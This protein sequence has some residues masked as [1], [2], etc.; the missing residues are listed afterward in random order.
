M[1]HYMQ[2]Q[3][4]ASQ[5][6]LAAQVMDRDE[7]STTSSSTEPLTSSSSITSPTNK[8]SNVN[9]TEKF[10]INA[11]D[12]VPIFLYVLSQTPSLKNTFFLRDILWNFCHPDL[13]QGEGGYILTV[14]ESALAYLLEDSVS[15]PE[16]SEP[17]HKK[18]N[19]KNKDKAGSH[20]DGVPKTAP[21]QAR[22][23]SIFNILQPNFNDDHDDT[24]LVRQSFT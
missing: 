11:D 24:A 5:E 18:K 2:Q 9:L 10:A 4:A 8:L 6:P 15:P 23:N 22:K 16:E 3:A 12:L 7:C 13:L 14:F 19:K 1:P 21:K 17:S 20:A